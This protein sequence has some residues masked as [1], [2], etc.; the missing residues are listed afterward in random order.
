MAPQYEALAELAP[1]TLFAICSSANSATQFAIYMSLANLG[2]SAG[3]KTYGMIAEQTS[4]VEAYLLLGAVTIAM[5]AIILFHRH[6]PDHAK[7]RKRAP[8]YTVSIGAGG[9]GMYF[10]GAMRCPKCRSDME[11]V[12]IDG[13]EVDRC[14]SCHGLWFDRGE[15]SKVR[16]RQAA[17]AL[18]I[19]DVGTGKQQ[20]QVEQYRCPRCAGPMIRL[21]DPRQT[22]IWFEQCNACR[23]SFFDAGELTDLATVS[24]SDFFKRFVTPERD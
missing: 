9:S 22:H 1:Q 10:S 15:L 24:V 5:I 13:T 20:N 16:N 2:S 8:S 21:V 4:Y 12:M 14:S 18:D 11:Q 6:R 17:A 19:G 3:A 7:S 23:G